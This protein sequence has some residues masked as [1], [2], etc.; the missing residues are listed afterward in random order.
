LLSGVKTEFPE[1][2]TV[3]EAIL[4]NA[5]LVLAHGCIEE[6]VEAVFQA[7]ADSLVCEPGNTHVTRAIA[8]AAFAWQ[9]AAKSKA[10][11]ERTLEDIV[12]AGSYRVQRAV[13]S[14]NG[15]KE[16]NIE[17]LAKAS[18][19]EWPPFE[20]A[21]NDALTQLE[22]LGGKRGSVAHVSASR[23]QITNRPIY[24]PEAKQWVADAIAAARAIDEYLTASR[25]PVPTAG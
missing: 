13:Q 6:H 10:F 23:S 7:Y 22:T 4:V 25:S 17:N 24:P 21:C 3:D 8:M 12:K 20:D 16:S 9:E 14:N 1:V 5:Y 15:I 2:P 18:G 11:R 19:V